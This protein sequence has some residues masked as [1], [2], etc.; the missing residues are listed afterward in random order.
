MMQSKSLNSLG[1]LLQIFRKPLQAGSRPP[2]ERTGV[3]ERMRSYQLHKLPGK[4]HD[5][6]QVF[7]NLPD[8]ER[9]LL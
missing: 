5:I 6:A 8:G 2:F 7:Q 1:F 4:L 9:D 3:A